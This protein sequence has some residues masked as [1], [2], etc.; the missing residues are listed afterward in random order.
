MQYLYVCV[1]IY[2][3]VYIL[4]EKVTYSHFQLFLF[5]YIK[6]HS[7]NLVCPPAALSTT[8]HLILMNSQF[9]LWDVTALFH[10]STFRFLNTSEGTH[11]YMWFSTPRTI[12][13]PSC[14]PVA[15]SQ[16]SYIAVHCS[17]YICSPHASLQQD[18]GMFMQVRR[19]RGTLSSGVF[20]VSR[21]VSLFNV[22]SYYNCDLNCLL[23]VSGFACPCAK[24]VYGSLNKYQKYCLNPFQ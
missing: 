15:L 7:E 18:N 13:C 12:S 2:M 1:S 5:L 16:A 9:L 20:R 4:T 19:K 21:K 24:I 8:V 3:Y 17:D 23:P 22:W 11:G 14:L 6:S 10:Q